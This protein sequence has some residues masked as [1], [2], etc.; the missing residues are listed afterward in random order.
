[1]ADPLRLA[2]ILTN[3]L[4]NAA[5]YTDPGGEIQL[6]VA[7]DRQSIV[8]AVKIPESALPRR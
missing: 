3:L 6:R 7:C 1:M 5:K 4:T 8:F 2:Q